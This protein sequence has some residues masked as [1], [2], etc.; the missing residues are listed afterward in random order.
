MFDN[1]TGYTEGPG[2]IA[3]RKAR[4]VAE[5]KVVTL[6]P[7]TMAQW[8]LMPATFRYFHPWE[9]ASK[10]LQVVIVKRAGDSQ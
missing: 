8:Y 1:H 9:R 2:K 4:I 3:A 7:M 5:K 10:P 6:P